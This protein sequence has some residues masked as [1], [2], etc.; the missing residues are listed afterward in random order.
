MVLDRAGSNITA[1]VFTDKAKVEEHKAE[2]AKSNAAAVAANK[3]VDDELAT[4]RKA[5]ADKVLELSKGDDNQRAV[6]QAEVDKLKAKVAELSA[7]R[8][9]VVVVIGPSRF[10]SQDEADTYI[11]QVKEVAKKV[12]GNVTVK[13]ADPAK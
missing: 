9:P 7:K 12:G 10:A 2:V 3:P 6:A 8:Q 4:V 11:E 5:L 1:I 13:T